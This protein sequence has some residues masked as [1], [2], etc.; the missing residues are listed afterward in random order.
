MALKVRLWL[1]LGRKG[2]EL[3]ERGKKGASEGPVMFYFLILVVVK[4][5]VHSV[6]IHRTILL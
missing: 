2:W 1:P 5:D 6:V 4:W 3:L